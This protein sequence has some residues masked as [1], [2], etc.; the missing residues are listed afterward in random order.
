MI[1]LPLISHSATEPLLFCHI[2]SALPSPLR[3]PTPAIFQD[4]S[5]RWAVP[6]I[7]KSAVALMSAPRNSQSPISPV[8]VLRQRTSEL[9]SPLRSPIPATI[10]LESGTGITPLVFAYPAPR[11]E[12]PFISQT[13]MA[14]LV[15]RQNRSLI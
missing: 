14:P 7:M 15:L 9:P 1:V 3:S 5:G 10:Q 11:I 2:R 4:A 13:D 12:V 6:P 8:N